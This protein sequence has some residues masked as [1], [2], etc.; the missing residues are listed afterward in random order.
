MDV[1][2]RLGILMNDPPTLN[3]FLRNYVNFV[4]LKP[5]MQVNLD[6]FN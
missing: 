1:T 4:K 6:A 5:E 2:R 3:F